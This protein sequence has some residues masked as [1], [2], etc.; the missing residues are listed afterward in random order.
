MDPKDRAARRDRLRARAVTTTVVATVVAAPVLALWAAYRGGP[1][2]RTTAAPRPRGR[3]RGPEALGGDTAGGYE[4]AGNAGVKPG[5]RTGKGGKA[6][7]S[8]EVV[9]V[10]GAGE[11]GARGSWPSAPPTTATRP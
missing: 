10:D 7:V 6:D 2:G 5:A 4:N 8:V 3:R 1:A 9:S 11:R